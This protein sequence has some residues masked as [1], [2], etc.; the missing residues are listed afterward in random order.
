MKAIAV[1]AVVVALCYAQEP[2]SLKIPE[3]FS[4]KVSASTGGDVCSIHPATKY[5]SIVSSKR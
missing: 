1:L 4:T 5:I 3:S 2:P